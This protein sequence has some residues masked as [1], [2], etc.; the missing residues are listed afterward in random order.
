MS[1]VQQN[2]PT[3][4]LGIIR[5]YLDFPTHNALRSTCSSVRLYVPQLKKVGFKEYK[6]LMEIYKI[7][8]CDGYN[9]R[10][11]VFQERIHL[12]L[13]LDE[14]T[15]N[16]L[17]YLHICDMSYELCRIA[18]K[19]FDNSESHRVIDFDCYYFLSAAANVG[20]L[21]LLIRL[22]QI[23]EMNPAACDNISIRVASYMGQ[24]HIVQYL[25]QDPRVDPSDV[26]NEAIIDASGNG[27]LAV[28]QALLNDPRVDPS[29]QDNEAIR[30]A[31]NYE[32]VE[33]VKVLLQ[34]PIV[35]NKVMLILG[36]V[37]E[38]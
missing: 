12:D 14:L 25:L 6:K 27:H 20:D 4:V 17:N 32:H 22:I 9:E 21:E 3:E 11:M 13:Y 15:M 2:L 24:L 38:S 8:F 16:Q 34:V 37:E 7:K 23:N 5:T 19:I 26:D 18:C 1:G 33:V 31:S 28:V 35:L 10:R 30:D 29:D 36:E